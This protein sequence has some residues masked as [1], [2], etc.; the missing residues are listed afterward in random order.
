M[1]DAPEILYQYT[2]FDAFRKIIG[3]IGDSQLFSP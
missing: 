2:S 3:K 1:G